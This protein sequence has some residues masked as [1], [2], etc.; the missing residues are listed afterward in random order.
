MM[1]VMMMMMTVKVN[2]FKVDFSTQ[3]TTNLKHV[4]FPKIP[5]T[6]ISVSCSPKSLMFRLDY[7]SVTDDLK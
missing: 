5:I 3:S 2:D 1:V 7:Q 4:D 6:V